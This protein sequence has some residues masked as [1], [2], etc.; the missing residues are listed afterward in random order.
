[1]CGITGYW[2]DQAPDAD[3]AIRMAA[4]LE[5]RGPD[6]AGAW[7][8]KA[9]G[10]ALAHR[11]LAIL[12]LSPAGHQPMASPCG[13]Y[14]LVY[15]GEIYNHQNLRKELEAKGSAFEW[16][17]HSDTET[18]L[19]AL[20]YWGVERT[21]ERLNGMFAF[22]L[23]DAIERKLLLAR[24]RM[25]I[26]PLYYGR[27]G[28]TFLFG[29]ELKALTVHP[30]WQGEVNRDALALYMRHNYVPAPWSIYKGISK[31][32]SGHFVVITNSG[33]DIGTPVCYW[34]LAQI[35]EQGIASS[36]G[37]PEVMIEELDALLRD[38]IGQRMVADVPLGAFL[39]GG[40]DSTTVTALMQAQSDRPVKTFSIGFHEENY[41]EAIH[42]KAVAKHLGTEHTELY[43][44][45]EEAMSVIPKLPTIYDEPFSDSSQIPTFLVSQL[46]R[47]H[48]TVSLSGDGGDELFFGYGRYY[49]GE[50]I[51]GKFGRVPL[52]VRRLA[53]WIVHYVPRKTLEK[54]MAVVPKRLR[55][56]HIADRLPK[57]AEILVHPSGE[58]F[59]RQLVSHWKEPD[60][61]I[62]GA[63]E[64]DT[65]LSRPDRLPRLPSLRERMMYLDMMTYLP[66]D[67]LTKVDRASMAVSLEA[68]VPLLDHRVVE[69]AWQV[70]TEYKYR[71]GKGK[72]LLRQVLYRYIPKEI[73]NRPK[74]GFGVPIEHWL[75]GPL[76]EWAEELLD[77]QRLRQEDFFDAK[78]IRKMWEEHLS[79]K[80]RWHYYLWDVLMF[81]AW[82]DEKKVQ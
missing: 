52:S 26:K 29:S 58:A 67:I 42:A 4:R 76:R 78:S 64:P 3:L 66:D 44:T 34:D 72:W 9:A 69:F 45:P 57:L 48:V 19:A 27:S 81:Q 25:G 61:L 68:R 7:T 18:L 77:E 17:G 74:K 13:R 33:H 80:R 21:L 59:Y 36:Y 50:R 54:A 41:N 20:R 47:R 10:L 65:I 40:Y 63:A 12:D 51:W 75:R 5:S 8:D 22:A 23:W 1:M 70:P 6:D 28:D 16:R 79:G 38:A 37:E 60:Q 35:A 30:D 62:Q 49:T 15:N 73:M 2:S 71:D 31:L 82:L 24:D 32:Q 55:I 56:Q 46:T 14:V 53:A 11:R 43:V 39:S